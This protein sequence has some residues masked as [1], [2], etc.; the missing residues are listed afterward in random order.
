[1]AFGKKKKEKIE[2]PPTPTKN[3]DLVKDA[4]PPEA[5]PKTVLVTHEEVVREYFQQI[6]TMLAEVRKDVEELKELVQKATK[7]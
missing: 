2:E 4:P 1:M 5:E 3:E 6:G 7:E